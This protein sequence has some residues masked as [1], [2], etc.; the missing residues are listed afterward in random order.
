[1]PT[2]LRD[3]TTSRG[4][5]VPDSGRGWRPPPRLDARS[6]STRAA[7]DDGKRWGKGPSPSG[8]EVALQGTNDVLRRHRVDA[9]WKSTSATVSARPNASASPSDRDSMT[10]SSHPARTVV[11]HQLGH[12]AGL[13]SRDVDAYRPPYRAARLL[14][15][16][17]R[18]APRAMRAQGRGDASRR[19]SEPP[20]AEPRAIGLRPKSADRRWTDRGSNVTCRNEKN[21]PS[22]SSGLLASRPPGSP[23][24]S[25][26]APRRSKVSSTP[27]A[28]NSARLQPAPTSTRPP[29]RTSIVAGRTGLRCGSTR[30]PMPRRMVCVAAASHDRGG[31][32]LEPEGRVDL[33]HRPRA[34]NVVGDPQ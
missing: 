30:T 6:S 2:P 1:M 25:A 8:G 33:L 27:R 5:S 21:S 11:L 14:V 23:G 15:E 28:R 19:R 3:P 26:A 7:P 10:T 13:E 32:R 12:A 29:E 18:P 24:S 16:P 31:H 20:G 4:A 34:D 22:C 17:A 9:H